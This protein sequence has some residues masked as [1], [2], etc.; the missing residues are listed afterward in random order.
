MGSAGQ[1]GSAERRRTMQIDSQDSVKIRLARV[2]DA[3]SLAKLRY[4]FRSRLG[5]ACEEEAAFV[6]RC[7]QW[8][9]ARLQGGSA[10]V[11]WVAEQDDKLIGNLWMQMIEK[12]PNPVI[13][14]EFHAYITNF[15]LCEQARGQGLGS[16]LLA[17][18]LNWA[19]AQDVHAVIL[20][21]TERSRALYLRH[22]FAV[23]ED[24]L[25]SLLEKD[26]SDT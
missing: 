19:Q 7:R 3:E 1:P 13:E 21:P 25:E 16:K 26:Q 23:R 22:G 10:W 24:L 18:A 20:W 9:Q 6:E 14:P 4:D 8:M 2:S 17:S 12:I 5:E 11:C 15:Y